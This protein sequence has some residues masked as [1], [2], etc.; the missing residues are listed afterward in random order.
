[1]S[2]CP[3]GYVCTENIQ[4]IHIAKVTANIFFND[5][6]RMNMVDLGLLLNFVFTFI[7]V[8]GEVSDIGNVLYIQYFVPEISR[9]RYMT[10][11]ET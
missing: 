3:R 4:R 10:S 9:Y 2:G 7:R 5:L 8:V 11:N 1:M 6:H